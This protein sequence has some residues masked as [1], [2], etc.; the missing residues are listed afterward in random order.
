MQYSD[1]PSKKEIRNDT[2]KKE[3]KEG[4]REKRRENIFG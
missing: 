2:K 4:E 1:T 3:G